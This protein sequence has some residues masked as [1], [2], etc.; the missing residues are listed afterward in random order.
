[1]R[2][3]ERTLDVDIP[4]GIHDGQRIRVQGQGHA[5]AAGGQPGDAFVQVRVLADERLAR[6]GDD[7]VA[8]VGLTMVDAAIGTTVTVPAADGEIE[9]EIPPGVQPGD[10]RVIRGKGMPNLSG[11]RRGDLRVHLD[12]RIPRRLDREQRRLLLEIGEQIGEDAYRD[13]GEGGFFER[14]RSAFR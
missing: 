1:R 2:L 3:E 9:V 14:L 4:A 5:G 13:D 7:L 12:V 10:V 11:G 6:D 8:V